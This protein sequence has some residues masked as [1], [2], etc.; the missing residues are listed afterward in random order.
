MKRY[1][2]SPYKLALPLV[3]VILGFM[4]W[5]SDNLSISCV[6]MAQRWDRAV[7]V[8][9][10]MLWN[11]RLVSGRRVRQRFNPRRNTER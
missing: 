2:L 8:A 5:R 10:L 6:Q 3:V 9:P 11:E 4:L 7:L 1:A